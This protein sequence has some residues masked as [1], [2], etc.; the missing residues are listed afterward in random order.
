MHQETILLLDG[1]AS[2]RGE[3]LQR[4]QEAGYL[5][6]ESLADPTGDIGIEHPPELVVA[7]MPLE[8]HQKDTLEKLSQQE[9]RPFFLFLLSSDRAQDATEA[10]E[11]GADDILRRPFT[12]HDL[13]ARLQLLAERRRRENLGRPGEP[14]AGN[15]ED[16]SV[17]ELL[18]LF[19]NRGGTATVSLQ[20]ESHRGRL[21]FR[22]GDLCAV[23]IDHRQ[24]LNALIRAMRWKTG[25]FSIS[26]EIE[27]SEMPEVLVHPDPIQAAQ[28]A[29]DKWDELVS[30]LPPTS[31][32]I[33]VDFQQV[34]QHLDELNDIAEQILW[35]LASHRSLEDV[36][37]DL[38]GDLVEALTELYHLYEK[39]FFSTRAEESPTFVEPTGSTSLEGIEASISRRSHRGGGFNDKLADAAKEAAAQLMAAARPVSDPHLDAHPDQFP[40]FINLSGVSGEMAGSSGSISSASHED[41]SIFPVDAPPNDVFNIGNVGKNDSFELGDFKHLSTAPGALPTDPP[42]FETTLPS[43]E[44]PGPEE[45][46][47]VEAS[48]AKEATPELDNAPAFVEESTPDADEDTGVRQLLQLETM[49]VLDRLLQ[50]EISSITELPSATP[51]EA[52]KEAS[53]AI[54]SKTPSPL[55]HTMPFGLET[56][57]PEPEPEPEPEPKAAAI[58]AIP[59]DAPTP[60]PSYEARIRLQ[61]DAEE[62]KSASLSMDDLPS[63]QKGSFPSLSLSDEFFLKEEDLKPV[64][65]NRFKDTIMYI[66]GGA[67]FMIIGFVGMGFLA[68][69]NQNPGVTKKG[70]QPLRTAVN[71]PR[72]APAPLVRRP[73]AKRRKAPPL[74]LNTADAGPTG[75]PDAGAPVGTAPVER[76]VPVERR[77]PVVVRKQPRPRP[78][79]VIRKRPKPRPRLIARARPKPRPRFRPRPRPRRVARSNNNKKAKQYLRRALSYKRRERYRQAESL[80]RRALKLKPSQPASYYSALG[81]VLYERDKAGQALRYLTKAYRISPR[82]TGA[83]LVTLGSIYYERKNRARAKQLYRQYLK[84]FPRGK[85]ANDARAMLNN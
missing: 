69:N 13:S 85:H 11:L 82:A 8:P 20:S 72:R 49:D 17:T 15:I 76:R 79:V 26:P 80:L 77:A 23:V 37:E 68:K 43:L 78:P 14:G 36:I 83:G 52:E 63:T 41:S 40:S 9:S 56:S 28:D 62:N 65:P 12:T 51:K 2:L 27:E 22:E 10:I 57:A 42:Q 47:A 16:V 38:D 66:M 44:A 67:I 29:V 3:N 55:S 39:N 46:A 24:G 32:S 33:Q 50:N 58:A 19:S 25:T 53:P 18:S 75:G 84:Y 74:V 71:T 45:I 7:S 61:P 64:K 81:Q 48:I 6:Q 60:A 31:H 73:V 34:Q 21:Y 30:K 70:K 1:D 4:I 5:V 54:K 35:Q 59:A